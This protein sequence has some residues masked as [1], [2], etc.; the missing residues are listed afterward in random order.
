MSF[1]NEA[2]IVSWR[3]ARGR[4]RRWKVK[5]QLAAI[6]ITSLFWVIRSHAKASFHSSLCFIQNL[7]EIFLKFK[8]KIFWC[9][10]KFRLHERESWAGSW[11]S[12]HVFYTHMLKPVACE[13]RQEA[14]VYVSVC[15]DDWLGPWPIAHGLH[16]GPY[17]REVVTQKCENWRVHKRGWEREEREREGKLSGLH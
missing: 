7:C 14:S 10:K 2:W 6:P 12:L 11:V 13:E 1:A 17:T 16:V 15:V 9:E 3:Q 5:A 4:R 8:A